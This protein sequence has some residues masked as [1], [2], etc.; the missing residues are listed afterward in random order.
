MLTPNKPEPDDK[1]SIIYIKIKMD[2]KGEMDID[3]SG[4]D[5]KGYHILVEQ[6]TPKPG[7]NEPNCINTTFIAFWDSNVNKYIGTAAFDGDLTPATD[8]Y[9]VQ[10]EFI[11]RNGG[12]EGTETHSADVVPGNLI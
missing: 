11:D 2:P 8:A 9:G 4:G 6:V 12:S 3:V 1:P 5:P 7:S 10:I